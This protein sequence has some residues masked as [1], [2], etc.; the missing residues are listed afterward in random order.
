MAEAQAGHQ[1]APAGN[2]DQR[3]RTWCVTLNN[4]TQEDQTHWTQRVCADRFG[5]LRFWVFQ[6]E[7]G[8][9]GTRHLQGVFCWENAKKFGQVKSAL[10]IRCHIEVCHNAKASIKYCSKRETRV[11]RVYSNLKLE[12]SI[13]DPMY[14]IPYKQWQ[15]EM[16][17]WFLGEPD[18]REIRWYY[19][20]DGGAGKSTFLKHLMIKY[21]GQILLAGGRAR[22]M[23][24]LARSAGNYRMV[25][26][27]L[28]RGD[29]EKVSYK[30]LE[31]IKDGMIVSTKYECSVILTDTPHVCVMS[32]SAPNAHAMSADRWNIIDIGIPPE[33][34]P[35]GQALG[36]I[37]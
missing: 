6:E 8:E 27:N 18:D 5:K 35:V 36:M 9:N 13:K 23:A 16:E 26:V 1:E 28:A 20:F 33:P 25:C 17:A 29:F 7:M 37:V 15:H 32:N 19:D 14:M 4:P 11:G 12:G 3:A 21:P 10:G 30:G 24:F 22:D 34:V 31:M 2:T